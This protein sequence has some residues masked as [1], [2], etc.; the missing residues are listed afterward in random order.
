MFPVRKTLLRIALL[1][2]IAFVLFSCNLPIPDG[3]TP[4]PCSVDF[5]RA[6]IDD[7][8]SNGPS[9]DVIDL[10]PGCVYELGTIEDTT[11]GNNGLPSITTSIVINGNGATIRRS[12][13]AQ[14][15]ALR[16][17]HVSSGGELVLNDITLLD[18]LGMKPA[19]VTDPL[20]NSGGAVFNRGTLTVRDSLITANRARRHGGGIYNIGTMTLIDSTIQN[21]SADIGNEPNESGGGIYNT[22]VAT[23]ANCTIA[24]NVASQ[25][26]SGIANSGSMTITNSTLSGNSTTLAEIASGAAVINAGTL[27]ISYTTITENIGTTSGAVFSAP[28]TIQISNSIIANNAPA[29][30]SY[31]ASSPVSG[32][33]LD[34][35]GSCHGFTITGD[36]LLGPLADNGGPTQTHGVDPSGPAADAATG[37]CPAADQRGETRPQGSACDL[38]SF[39]AAG[40]SSAGDSSLLEGLVFDDANADGNPDSGEPGLPGVELALGNGGCPAAA[41]EWSGVT[42]ADGSFQIEVPPPTAGTYCL[43]ID[44]LQPPNDTILI[45]GEF[46]DPP[47]GQLEIQ[48][49]EGEDLADLLFAWDFQFAGTQGPDLVISNVDLSATTIQVEEWVEV[50]VTV[51]NQGSETAS[52]YELVLIPHYGVGPPNPAGY[53]T[54]PDLAPGASH[55]VTFSPGVFYSSAGSYTLRVLVTDDWYDIG[56]PDSTGTAGDVQDF[57]I[58]VTGPN[59]VIVNVDLSSTNVFVGEWVEVEVTVENQG[60]VAASGFDMVLI[61]HYGVGPPNPAGYESLP[62]LAPGDSHTVTF[63]PG[64]LYSSV[65]SHTLRVLVSDVW[66]DSGDP[67]STGSGGDYQDIP[68][69]VVDH[70]GMF[71]QIEISLVLLDV[72]PETLQFPL[73]FKIPGGVPGPKVGELWNYQAQLGEY[74]AYACGLEGFEDRLYCYFQL[75][76]EAPGQ[77]KDLALYTDGCP[78]PV[79]TAENVIIPELE[80]ECRRDLGPE[81]CEAAGGTMSEGATTAPYCICP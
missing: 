20:P 4:P 68:I 14:K 31:P 22:G 71:N 78:D 52:G 48:L 61:P 38:G 55:T 29:D 3:S 70:C 64:V 39:E 79:Y 80:I 35:D 53:E 54:L 5:L 40:G 25:S 77:V 33:N 65:G 36:P 72:N 13:A 76:S 18:G 19:D 63:S 26:A 2:V 67:D 75:P 1:T 27:T 16:L 15:M 24:N 42:A 62:D 7:A 59:L 34:S 46:T 60:A 57:T 81:E 8:N 17:L 69:T 37:S 32:T 45:P 50:E 56:D 12:T 47:G 58:T 44:P 28:D 43:S 23:I 30:C 74:E 21:N 10:D 9:T 49:S 66:M 51:E 6:S 11:D 73:Y 41:V